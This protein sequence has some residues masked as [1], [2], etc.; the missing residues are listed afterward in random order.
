MNQ[1][2]GGSICL[3]DLIEQAKK[4]HSA[5]SKSVKNGKVYF[6]MNTWINEEKDKF[7]N[8]MSHQ[9]NSTKE[10]REAE[11]KIYIGNSKELETSKPVSANDVDGDLGN[12]PERT[13]ETAAPASGQDDL[14]F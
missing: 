9:L 11:G 2:F 1:L 13:T 3:T 6:N 10:K 8:S 14:P 7:G 12:V 5:F 4:G